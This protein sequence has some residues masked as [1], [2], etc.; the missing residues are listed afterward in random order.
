MATLETKFLGMTLSNPFLIAAGPAT[1]TAAKVIRAFKAGWGGVVMKTFGLEPTQN[2]S[3]RI[4]L[5]RSG[6]KNYGMFDIELFSSHS[7]EWWV[8]QIG[9]IRDA[10]PER[11]LIASIAGGADPYS[12]QELVRRVEP[13]GVNAFEMNLSCPSFDKKRG[14]KLGQDPQALFQ[15]VGWVREATRL[16]VIVKLTPNVTDI[17]ELARVALSAGADAFTSA[18]SLTGI[19]GIDLDSFSPLPAVDGYGIVGGYGGLGLKPVSLRCVA[20]IS[21]ALGAPILGVGGISRWQDAV[22]YMAVGASAVQVCTAVMLEGFELVAD[23]KKGLSS[24][25]EEKGFASPADIV[26]RSL[27]KLSV[28][29]T[30]DL[31]TRKVA[32]IDLERCNS[33]GNCA[34]ACGAGG[35]EA[36]SMVEKLPDVDATLCDGCGLCDS[37]CTTGAIEMVGRN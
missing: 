25:L 10:F 4:M 32:R 21:Q 7:F 18:N 35:F 36:I 28:F 13:L 11:P 27:P 1:S 2:V 8:S 16:P 33:C 26:G 14:S 19:A 9:E 34:R 5:I 12:W 37:V 6:R 23:L 17:V 22:E 15:T 3:P 24:Y 20:N 30:L 31:T 29:S